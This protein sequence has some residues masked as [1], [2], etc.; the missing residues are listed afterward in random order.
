MTKGS[1]KKVIFLVGGGRKGL[2]TKKK[3]VFFEAWEK[4]ITNKNSATK[5]EGGGGRP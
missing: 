1:R 2:A 5:L 3:E 4:K